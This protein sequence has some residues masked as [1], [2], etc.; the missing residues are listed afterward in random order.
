[1]IKKFED[2]TERHRLWREHL[3]ESCKNRIV[4]QKTKRKISL[5]RQKQAPPM[6]NKHHSIESRDKS[7]KTWQN[8]IL[9]G[10]VSPMKNV[11]LSEEHKAKIGLSH[12]G[13]YSDET[14]R[15]KI[16]SALTGRKRSIE[17]VR[18]IA[19]SNT[20]QIRNDVTKQNISNGT[21]IWWDGMTENFR[22]SVI[23]KAMQNSNA[24]TLRFPTKH[25]K[26]LLSILNQYFPNEWKYVG[27]GEFILGGKCPDFMNCNGKKLLI[28]LFD[29]QWH[30]GQTGQDRISHFEKYGFRTLIVHGAELQSP[31]VIVAK[32]E[33]LLK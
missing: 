24:K 33:D 25:E 6:L 16:S 12:I 11:P 17:V 8:K 3:S 13:I 21:K 7:H 18:K 14:T 23:S 19:I 20:G 2:E 27:A 30:F 4:S 29:D 9:N 28:E 15:K 31:E 22:N 26:I 5:A 1:M 10:Y 32:I